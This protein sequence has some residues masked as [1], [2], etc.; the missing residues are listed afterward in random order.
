MGLRN[1]NYQYSRTIPVI[2]H[3]L[4]GYDSHLIIKKILTCVDGRIDLL[5]LTMERYVSFTEHIVGSKVTVRFTDSSRFMASSLEKLASY[6]DTDK[7]TIVKREFALLDEGRLK[8]LMKKGVFPYDYLDL[9]DKL[10]EIELPP[11][12][13]F[14]SALNNSDYSAED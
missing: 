7:K 5:P 10:D 2:F 11:T 3:N 1:L 14:H 4:C 12:E 6:L 8:L 13:A 9:W